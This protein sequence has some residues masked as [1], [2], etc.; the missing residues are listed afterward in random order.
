M[1]RILVLVLA[2]ANLLF[3]GWSQWI[4]QKTPRL[5][6]P[7]PGATSAARQPAG[8]TRACAALGPVAD[9]T[10]ALEIDA[11]LRDMQLVPL[12]RTVT[13]EVPDGWWVYLD[14][15]DAA[16]RA[17]AL[18]TIENAGL[19]DAVALRED[20]QY[21]IS[22]G[23]FSD[24]AR[25]MA[26]ADQVRALQLEPGVGQRMKEET[27]HWFVLPGTAPAAV[28]LARLAAEGV[29]TR[30]LRVQECDADDDVHVDAIL[31]N[32]ASVP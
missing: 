21:R 14:N 7:E 15:A 12:R 5:V 29:D 25:A 9:E 28:S 24:P 13:R 19:G 1:I 4:G 22:V 2:A 16:A 26:R 23:V 27:A 20:P 18:R 3:F 32:G 10:A 17:R 30:P 31:P 8:N 6:A 11:L